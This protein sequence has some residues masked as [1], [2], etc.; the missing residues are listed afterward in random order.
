[1]PFPEQLFVLAAYFIL[2]LCRTSAL[3]VLS[4]ILGRANIP[5]LVKAGLALFLAII[6]IMIYPPFDEVPAHSLMGYA[7]LVL[8]ELL[9]GLLFGY[10]TTLF[11]SLVY[12]AGQLIDT[13]AGLGMVNV[14]DPQSGTQVPIFGSLLN[15]ALILAFL[16]SDGHVAL[17]RLLLET[18]TYLPIGTGMLSTAA[19]MV[20]VDA[21]VTTIEIGVN[22]AMPVI[23]AALLV[24]VGLG[25]IV[26]TAPQMNIFIIGIPIRV[27]VGFITVY[28]MI[29]IFIRFTGVIFSDMFETIRLVLET[30]LLN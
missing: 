21:F 5:N 16:L 2:V 20:V 23:A 15:I 4:P 9:I 12:T 29:P 18:Y 26:R 10:V 6:I 13:Q 28:L 8:N 11:F 25:V 3:F 22:I 24:E 19:V 27:I 7:V 14:F 17:A 30:A 1:M